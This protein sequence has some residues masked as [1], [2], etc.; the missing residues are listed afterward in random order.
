MDAEDRAYHRSRYRKMSADLDPQIAE[1]ER[2]L[3]FLRERAAEMASEATAGAAFL[4]AT[5]ALAG[6]REA[7]YE[8]MRAAALLAVNEGTPVRM[9]AEHADVTRATVNNWRNEAKQE[10]EKQQQD[11]DL[12]PEMF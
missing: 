11:T 9:V 6:I 4:A 12:P 2:H 5:G 3:T 7:S 1:I 8:A 10:A